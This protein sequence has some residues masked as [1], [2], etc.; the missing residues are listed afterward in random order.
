MIVAIACTGVLFVLAA[1]RR[2]AVRRRERLDDEYLDLLLVLVSGLESGLHPMDAIGIHARG[3]G[4]GHV[5]A[6]VTE[7]WSR[8]GRSLEECLGILSAHFDGGHEGP[9]FRGRGSHLAENLRAHLLDGQPLTA[10]IDSM[11][12][13]VDDSVRRATEAR[14]RELPV[15]LSPPLVLCILPSFM[16]ACVLPLT[17]MTSV[18]LNGTGPDSYF[19]TSEETP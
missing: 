2:R 18:S 8:R 13:D 15:R 7:A 3:R 11:V 4:Q 17:A 6:R 1:R 5:A 14:T 10:S 16:L 9:G 12:R 19:T